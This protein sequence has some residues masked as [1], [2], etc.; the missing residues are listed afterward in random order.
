MQSPASSVQS[1]RAQGRTPAQPQ[2]P[3]DKELMASLHVLLNQLSEVERQ[4]LV[5]FHKIEES[6]T[7]PYTQQEAHADTMNLLTHLDTLT[8]QARTTGFGALTMLPTSPTVV[9]TPSGSSGMPTAGATAGATAAGTPKPTF[10]SPRMQNHIHNNLNTHP[11]NST[12]SSS[13]N[14]NHSMDIQMLSPTPL[15]LISTPA[16]TAATVPG[17]SGAAS[18]A[19]PTTTTTTTPGGPDASTTPSASTGLG[20]DITATSLP[21]GTAESSSAAT[22]TDPLS[23]TTPINPATP[24][25]PSSQLGLTPSIALVQMTDARQK[26]VNALDAEKRKLKRNLDTAARLSRP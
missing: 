18:S 13:N 1:P 8:T 23:A 14:S 10:M 24:A 2:V 17:T 4:G 22:G 12:N 16:S 15:S 3:F 7:H 11:Y 20:L 6:F 5:M 9:S 21:G 19:A 25:T 26:D